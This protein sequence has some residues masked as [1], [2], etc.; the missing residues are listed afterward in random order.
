M[1]VKYWIES[2]SENNHW[3]WILTMDGQVEI[4][5]ERELVIYNE[6]NDVE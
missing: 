3:E 6:E 5:S 1:F 4:T 2:K